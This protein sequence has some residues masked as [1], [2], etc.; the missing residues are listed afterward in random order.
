MSVS[1]PPLIKQRGSAELR[2]QALKDVTIDQGTPYQISETGLKGLRFFRKKQ[3]EHFVSQMQATKEICE[4][5]DLEREPTPKEAAA[6]ARLRAALS[7]EDW[8]PDVAIKTFH[9]MDIIFFAGR[10]QGNVRAHWED[11]PFLFRYVPRTTQ[12]AKNFYADR[13]WEGVDE[14]VASGK[15]EV[16]WTLWGRTWFDGCPPG[17]CCIVLNATAILAKNKSGRLTSWAQ[18]WAVLL[19]EMCHAYTWV[20]SM[21]YDGHG[22]HFGTKLA[23]VDERWTKLFGFASNGASYDR[24]HPSELSN[25]ASEAASGI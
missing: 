5:N 4:H 7:F 14:F 13:K 9:D 17:K 19:H 23:A 18:I 15:K 2:A 24:L 16:T 20:R 21:Q 12:D 25:G 22:K 1:T 11:G 6:I 8:H 3:V 10:L